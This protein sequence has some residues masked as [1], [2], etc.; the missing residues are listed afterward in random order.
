MQYGV[1]KI[2]NAFL[3]EKALHE[4]GAD[5]SWG[6]SVP[7]KHYWM[8]SDLPLESQIIPV[9]SFYA[10]PDV[11]LAACRELAEAKHARVLQEFPEWTELL[12]SIDANGVYEK[13]LTGTALRASIDANIAKRAAAENG[14]P[15]PAPRTKTPDPETFAPLSAAE[16]TPTTETTTEA[17]E[18]MTSDDVQGGRER[19]NPS[20]DEMKKEMIRMGGNA[21][22]LDEIGPETPGALE[23]MMPRPEEILNFETNASR[24]HSK[25][26]T[27]A[28]LIAYLA[29]EI[30]PGKEFTPEE[31]GGVCRQFSGKSRSWYRQTISSDLIA[32]GVVKRDERKGVY[33]VSL[34]IFTERVQAQVDDL[35]GRIPADA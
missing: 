29:K 24:P 30:G 32:M 7:G 27:L 3:L 34:D 11:T 12:K 8:R 23:S 25:Q 28:H 1:T 2:G 19:L 4:A 15:V 16:P 21:D 13:R 6:V 33:R 9:R 5:P 26:R 31:V 17:E 22:W 14:A 10:K 35:L 20:D 18:N